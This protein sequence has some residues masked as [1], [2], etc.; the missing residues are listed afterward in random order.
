MAYA[1][2]AQVC[3]VRQFSAAQHRSLYL[4]SSLNGL[5]LLCQL[6]LTCSHALEGCAV[7]PGL[8]Q[9][10]STVGSQLLQ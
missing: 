6:H 5:T 9:A 7:L 10:C 2:G 3:Q 4:A 1:H 8:S